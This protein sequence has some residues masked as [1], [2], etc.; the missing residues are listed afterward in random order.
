[1]KLL[2]VLCAVQM[3]ANTVVVLPF[4]NASR[5][6]NLD[7]VGESVAD[8]L[9]EVIAWHGLMSLDRED[10]NEAY[11]RLGVRTDVRLTRA[12]VVKLGQALDAGH[13]VYGEFELT[14]PPAGA[15]NTRGSLRITAHIL[16]LKRMKQGPEFSEVGAL[17]DLGA[18][19]AHLAWQMLQFLMPKAAPSE[20]DF[21]R[22]WPQVRVDAME[23]YIRGLL[24]TNPEQ[25]QKLFFQ[26]A[27][28]EPSFSE[29]AYQLGVLALSK[30][31]YRSASD[32]L[33]KVAKNDV[34]YRFARFYYGICRF[35]LGDYAAA[36]GAFET[37]AAEVPLNEVFNNLGAAQSRRNQP[38]A[39]ETLKKA[40]D[41]DPGD[42]AYH[43]NVGYALWKQ[44]RFDEAAE[45]F[46]ATLERDPQDAQAT[47]ML[48]R[49]LA[50]SAPKPAD[51][52]QEGLERLK[53]KYEESAY[54]QL[55]AVLQPE[56]P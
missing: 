33:Q 38:V 13:V 12:T 9:R 6:P 16:D 27:R 34:H 20:A 37:V 15:A 44:G 29:P 11:R 18:Q 21:R 51:S 32:W 42:P 41:G 26:A 10:R 49:C 46:R 4:S 54:W 40:L 47:T 22:Q 2:V 24:A 28:L 5:T 14:P 36:Q 8:T 1:M 23:S 53:T 25:K 17:E 35:Q 30:N 56:K 19:Q 48:G 7:W 50:K 31:D 43:F 52:K 3:A 45:H 55:K 39:V